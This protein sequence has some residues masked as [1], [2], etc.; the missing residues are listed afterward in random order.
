MLIM[1]LLSFCIFL[2]ILYFIRYF[3]KSSSKEYS[4]GILI[5]QPK[6]KH[7][8]LPQGTLRKEGGRKS[9]CNDVATSRIPVSPSASTVL[10]D[11]AHHLTKQ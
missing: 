9:L 5:T 7:G 11:R 10:K 1:R 3:F 2:S 4:E 6:L 8:G